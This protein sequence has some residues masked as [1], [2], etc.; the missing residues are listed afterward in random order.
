M[1][2]VIGGK[3]K[4]K[5]IRR[6]IVMHATSHG[7]ESGDRGQGGGQEGQKRDGHAILGM[8]MNQVRGDKQE[9]KKIK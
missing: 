8:G 7:D 2:Q 5:K 3:G 9:I 4:V 1:N 6:E